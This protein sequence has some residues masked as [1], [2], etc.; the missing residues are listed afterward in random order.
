MPKYSIVLVLLFAGLSLGWSSL[1]FAEQRDRVRI[2]NQNLRADNGSPLRGTHFF[3]DI[4]SIEDMRNNEAA[5]RNYF[6]EI[7]QTYKMNLVRTSVYLG[8]YDYMQKDGGYYEQD[9]KNFLYVNDKVVEWAEEDGIYVI[10]M[11]GTHHNTVLDMQRSTDYWSVFAPRYKDKKHVIYELVNEPNIPSARRVMGDLYRFVRARAPNTHI[12]CWSLTN[13]EDMSA[14]DI[15][16]H[17][18]KIDYSNASVGFH[19]Y[20]FIVDKSQQWD[21]ALAYRRNGLPV[22]NTEFYSLTKAD[23][24][25]IDYNFLASNIRMAESRGFSWTQFAPVANYRF[26]NKRRGDNGETVKHS[27]IGFS[28]AYFEALEKEGV[29]RWSVDSTPGA[30]QVSKNS[31]VEL[32]GIRYITDRWKNRK[33]HAEAN[34]SGSSVL[35]AKLVKDWSS[36]K[37]EFEHISGDTYRIKNVW[38]G[39]YLSACGN[40]E[41]A[42][43]CALDLVRS[44]SS[45]KWKLEKVGSD[46]RIRNVWSS[47]YLSAPGSEW[48]SYRLAALNQSWSSQ[49]YTITS[50]N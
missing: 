9:L 34:Y 10:V 13:P 14:D 45:M 49:R 27:D 32:N 33:L 22:I 11:M 44:W 5:Y 37:W 31:N 23:Y 1:S 7:S 24:Y 12:I 8:R 20:D 41:W 50:T 25:P 43:A 39:R 40:W 48:D 36:Q 26:T 42:E 3:L 18:S 16:K 17:S 38:T 46:Y 15:W 30:N 4:F 6:R 21:L 19:I 28:N 47:K 35:S 2:E 29:S